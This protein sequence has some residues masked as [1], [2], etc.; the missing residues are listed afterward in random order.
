MAVAQ[1]ALEPSGH[2]NQGHQK[3]SK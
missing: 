3:E 1:G 2:L